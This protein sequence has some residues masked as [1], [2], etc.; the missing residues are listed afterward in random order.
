MTQ[1][2]DFFTLINEKLQD[3]CESFV[4]AHDEVTVECSKEALL[5]CLYLLR[6]DKELA[7]DQLIDLCG[8]DYLLHGQYDWT[9]YDATV[10]GFSRGVELGENTSTTWDKPRFAVVY[11]LLSTVHNQRIRLRV[12]LQDDLL[13]IPSVHQ[14]GLSVM[15]MTYSVFYL[16][17]ILI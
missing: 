8:V 6:D 14:I 10:T 17:G 12:F 4:L 16:K 3:V 13:T 1:N 9:T 11:H 5:K 15:H 7:F 2:N